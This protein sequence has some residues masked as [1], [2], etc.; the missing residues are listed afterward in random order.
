MPKFLNYKPTY[1][2]LN[3][4]T[5]AAIASLLT[6]ITNPIPAQTIKGDHWE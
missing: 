1:P 6:S 2:T 3:N 5:P 4:T